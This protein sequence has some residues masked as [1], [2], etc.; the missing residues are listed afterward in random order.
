[1]RFLDRYASAMSVAVPQAKKVWTEA[2]LQALPEDG[3][4]HEVV[5]GELVMSPKNNFQHENIC[6]RLFLALESFNR[7]HKLGVVL[8]SSAGFWMH[9]RNCR[10]PD[11]SFIPKARLQQ[12][13][14]RPSTR[15]F[16][17]GAPDLAV[18]IL[19][20]SN[21]RSEI[22]ER[23][24]DFFASGTQIAWIINPDD[25]CAEVCHSLV[26]RQLI[27]TGGFLDGDHLL[28][29]FQFPIADLFTPQTVG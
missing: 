25:E 20:P 10:A 29:S 28:P 18:E 27:G 3:F 22:D 26:K 16:F 1:M 24:N 11:V 6:G 4:S 21:T 19:A 14:F 9:N 17:P 12:L 2:E 5:N 8:G 15:R 7:L 13:G 23:L